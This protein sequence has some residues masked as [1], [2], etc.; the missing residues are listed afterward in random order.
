M[1]LVASR[2]AEP[3]YANKERRKAHGVTYT[4]KVLADFVACEIVKAA[5]Q[6]YRD[7]IRV[8][9]PAVGDGQLLVSLLDELAGK[10]V[11]DIEVHGFETDE[12]ALSV[13]HARLAKRVN[14]TVRFRLVRANFLSFVLDNFD[15]SRCLFATA[16]PPYDIVIANPPYV[17]TQIIGAT[18]AQNLAKLF[19]LSGRVDLYHAFV[20]GL[21]LV[22]AS[23]GISGIIVPN[24]LMTTK[25]GARVR[26]TLLDRL[27]LL[28]AWDLGDTKLFDA[29]VLPAVLIA[30]CRTKDRP[31]TKFTSIY[32]TSDVA[33]AAAANPIEA[34]QK[35]GVV[36]VD[37]GRRFA[38]RHGELN[39]GGISGIWRISTRAIDNWLAEVERHRWCCFG[40]IGRVRVGV[41]TCADRVFI[42][43]DWDA[44][45]DADR[46]ELLRP[47]A[48]HHIARQYRALA[49]D[50]PRQI[51]YPHELFQGRRR[52][53]DLRHYPASR[54]YLEAHRQT[55]QRRRYVVEAG[56]AWYELWVPQDP[57]AWPLPKLVFRDIAE[58]P[59]FWLDTSG[60]IVN[61]DCYWL[62]QDAAIDGLA[63]DDIL[64][65]VAAV[66]NSTLIEQFY[67]FQYNNKLYAGRRRFA[68]Q[69]VENF[70]LPNPHSSIGRELT[71]AAKRVFENM[72]SPESAEIM[73]EVDAM[74]WEA[75]G[76][77]PPPPTGDR[78]RKSVGGGSGTSCSKQGLGIGQTGQ[79][80]S[81]R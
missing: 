29:A 32:E 4:P 47:V 67:D 42:R 7:P 33:T 22:L 10:G 37:D 55:L 50:R 27:N 25:S 44:L 63:Q 70:P 16:Q 20:L 8:L 6:I 43:E 38:V 18:K 13:A 26:A 57:S 9:D 11:S 58:K 73:D 36:T 60:S 69:Y 71:V 65:L 24:R 54:T 51:L 76:L 15:R 46:P 79:R 49:T 62:K 77:R 19:G 14:G 3:R 48:T 75:F 28:R 74:V 59:A 39:T 80:T 61:G 34:L 31:A 17:R 2:S 78:R 30:R 45:A 5:P 23:N 52:A 40:D 1:S 21:S 35:E 66:G 12:D 68:T 72:P 64:W 41:K 81:R 53:V 56:R